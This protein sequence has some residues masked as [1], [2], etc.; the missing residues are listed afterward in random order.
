MKREEKNEEEIQKKHTRC[1]TTPAQS[2]NEETSVRGKE[3]CFVA[4]TCVSVSNKK[5]KWNEHIGKVVKSEGKKKSE[6]E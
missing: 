5:S 1:L 3:T 2:T 4:G 6:Q